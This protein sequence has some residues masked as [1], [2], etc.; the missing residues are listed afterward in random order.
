MLKSFVFGVQ[1]T[2]VAVL[3]TSGGAIALALARG[4]AAVRAPRDARRHSARHRRKLDVTA[5]AR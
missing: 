5:D 2:S 3:A 4:H 1:L